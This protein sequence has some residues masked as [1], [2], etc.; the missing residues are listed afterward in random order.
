MQSVLIT[1]KVVISNPV[2]DEVH[3]IQH[4]VI[5]FFSDLQQVGGFLR[6]VRFL[7]LIKQYNRNIFESGV[8]LHKPT[9]PLFIEESA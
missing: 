4:Y 2:H 3:S 1:T 5:K 7:P 8:K 6:V 9:K